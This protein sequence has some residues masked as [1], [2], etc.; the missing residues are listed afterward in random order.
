MIDHNE[1]KNAAGNFEQKGIKTSFSQKV[2]LDS[3]APQIYS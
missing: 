2:D 3:Y 1:Q